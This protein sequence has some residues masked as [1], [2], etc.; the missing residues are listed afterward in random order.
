MLDKQKRVKYSILFIVIFSLLINLAYL[1][2][3]KN[4]ESDNYSKYNSEVINYHKNFSENI[5]SESV[6]QNICSELKGPLRDIS[7]YYDLMFL[8]VLM[9]M[10]S[11]IILF[12]LLALKMLKKTILSRRDLNIITSIILASSSIFFWAFMLESDYYFT[13]CVNF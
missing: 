9:T 5:L 12:A 3:E 8:A 1:A 6:S 2:Y 13:Y 10:V 11:I 4:Y 7:T